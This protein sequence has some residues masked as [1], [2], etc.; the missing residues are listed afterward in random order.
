M[1]AK[2]EL[3]VQQQDLVSL[4]AVMRAESDGKKL[5]AELRTAFKT[6][7]A[8]IVPEIQ[9][10]VL[11]YHNAGLSVESGGSLGGDRDSLGEAV[12]AGVKVGV[13]LSGRLT[14]ARIYISKKGMPRGFK[15]AP[16]D[17][18]KEGG[19][20]H[21]GYGGRGKYKQVG[22]V[23]FF[24]KPIQRKL[25]RARELCQGVMDQMAARIAARK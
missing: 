24:D 4:R 22:P 1:P 10:G 7:L 18:N 8:E 6:A 17:L 11:E 16:R 3:S 5:E 2:L 20:E 23:G 21:P 15:N 9:R 14:G 25:T 13:S 12:A 19:W